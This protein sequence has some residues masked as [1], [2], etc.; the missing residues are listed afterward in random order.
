MFSTKVMILGSACVGKTSLTKRLVFDRF[1]AEYKSTIGV[2]ILSHEIL[3]GPDCANAA[4][5]LIL[6]DTDGNFESHIF[7]SAH[8]A[9][10][11]G[12]VIVS[13]ISRPETMEVAVDFCA[14]FAAKFPGR[15]IRTIINKIDL[16]PDPMAVKIPDF[17]PYAPLYAS[18]KTGSGVID[19]FRSIGEAIWRRGLE[20]PRGRR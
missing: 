6:W 18:A 3:L 20:E 19:L 10:A 7:T 5:R 15:P 17:A 12:A 1:D 4:M 11:S 16:V 8:V 13:D 2:N 9:G 14:R